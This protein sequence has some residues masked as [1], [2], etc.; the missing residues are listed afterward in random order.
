MGEHMLHTTGMLMILRHE[1]VNV[2]RDGKTVSIPLYDA[3]TTSEKGGWHVELAENIEFEDAN[4]SFLQ[5]IPKKDGKVVIDNHAKQDKLFENLAVYINNI[6]AGMHGGYSEIEKGNVNQQAIWRLILQFRQWMFGMYNKAYSRSY[7][8]AVT[9]TMKEGGYVSIAKFL[10]GTIHDMKNMGIKMAIENNHLTP[11][12]RKNATVALSQTALFAL[13][14]VLCKMTL[15]WKDEDDRYKRLLAYSAL[16]LKTET[17]A[18]VPGT[19]LV[20][21]IFTLIQS[22]AA[23]V[24]TLETM[25]AIFD[26][27]NYWDEINSGRYKGWTVAEKAIY[28][29]TPLYNIQKLI[30]MKDYNYM[31]NI[32]N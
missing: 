2:K 11:E 4:K 25:S 10:T 3:I 19:P 15:G 28:T 5:G 13:L 24:K 14:V 8:D 16:R 31:F 30:D 7:Y 6:N 12:E 23:G 20:K 22:P 26:L 17:G 32:F 9:Q 18:F 21:N 27:N 1:K 29:T